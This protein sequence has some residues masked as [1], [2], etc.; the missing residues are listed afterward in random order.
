MNTNFWEAI[1]ARRTYY[2]IGDEAV[3]G[4]ERIMNVVR[5]AVRHVPSSFNSQ[6]GRVVVLLGDNHK[7]L[8]DI[9]KAELR[10]MVPSENYPATEA[11]IDGAF[12]SGYG[13]I[14]FFEDNAVVQGLME[15]FPAYRENF[16]VWS[17]QSSGMLQFT[18][19]T[20]LEAEGWGASLQHYNPV[21]DDEV[22]ASWNID[23]NWK[24]VAQ[25]PF[26][27]P[28]AAPNEKDFQAIDQRVFLYT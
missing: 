26:G 15:K 7:R 20:A 25:M 2:Q 12:K 14:L 17:Q 28:V 18:I 27:K 23:P 1:K 11:K 6:S 22:K 9:T 16:P 8:W 4:D 10:K 21:I 24:L 13:T 5:D 19:W 3:T